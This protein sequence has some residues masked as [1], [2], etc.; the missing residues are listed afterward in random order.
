M[1]AEARRWDATTPERATLRAVEAPLLETALLLGRDLDIGG[2]Q[3][4]D[5]IGNPLHL[6]PQ[7]IGE[8]AGEVDQPAGQVAV[9][10]LQVDDHG[11][12]G[13]ELVPDLLGVVEARGSDDMH[14]CRL[15]R[16]HRTQRR[17]PGLDGDVGIGFTG[18][19]AHARGGAFGLDIG[20]GRTARRGR[21]R[22]GRDRSRLVVRL[23]LLV[24][25]VVDEPQI[26]HDSSPGRSHVLRRLLG[27]RAYRR[28][29]GPSGRGPKSPRPILSIVVPSCTAT[30]RSSVMPIERTGRA[31]RSARATRD[32]NPGLAVSGGP[33]GPI[34]IR[35]RTSRPRRP[36]SS[37]SAGISR[38]A[39]PC[40]W[41]SPLMFTC[42]RTA[43]PGARLAI[44][45]AAATRSTACQRLTKS[46]IL[47][48][49][50]RWTRPR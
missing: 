30:S 47:R 37:T 2:R 14:P 13:F 10:R 1:P 15:H 46:A 9:D 18:K 16:G 5:L 45:W 7:A 17:R 25:V 27:R 23:V 22:W 33:V 28:R 34:A 31:R 6:A 42:T 4:E 36:R 29:S 11:L 39:A 12:V 26:D 35:P 40:F 24:L 48:T 20:D 8:A 32:L 38:S 41:G 50:L 19:G 49:W 44:S 21:R 43:A 3:Q